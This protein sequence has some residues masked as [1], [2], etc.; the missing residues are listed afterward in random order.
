MIFNNNYNYIIT[1]FIYIILF[2]L[3]IYFLLNLYKFNIFVILLTLIITCYFIINYNKYLINNSVNINETF[4]N[5]ND[6]SLLSKNKPIDIYK[7]YLYDDK[8]K[9][10]Y[11]SMTYDDYLK[12]DDIILTLAD[13]SSNKNKTSIILH[14]DKNEVNNHNKKLQNIY[15]INLGCNSLYIEPVMENNKNSLYN[16]TQNNFSFIWNMK[17]DNKIFN[18]EAVKDTLIDEYNK[19][20]NNGIFKYEI[21][22][23]RNYYNPSHNVHIP[24]NLKCNYCIRKINND[25][26]SIKYLEI[27]L[28]DGSILNENNNASLYK[29]LYE[30]WKNRYS[31]YKIIA[32]DTID[33]NMESTDNSIYGFM[34]DNKEHTF[35]LIRENNTLKLYIDKYLV[36]ISINNINNIG[37]SFNIN[38]KGHV[39][40]LFDNE[41]DNNP[42]SFFNNNTT[43]DINNNNPGIFFN[44]NKMLNDS[45]TYITYIS[46][47]NNMFSND[48]VKILNNN[49]S[50]LSQK[51]ILLSNEYLQN[52]ITK[53]NEVKNKNTL[54]TDEIDKLKIKQKNCNFNNPTLCNICSDASIT[55]WNDI[56]DIMTNAGSQECLN[57]IIHHC[58]NDPLD[59]SCPFNKNI[60][61][62]INKT[63]QYKNVNVQFTQTQPVKDTTKSDT[64]ETFSEVHNNNQQDN[65]DKNNDKNNDRKNNDKNNNNKKKNDKKKNDKNNNKK[66]NENND[67]IIDFE[68][69]E[70]LVNNVI[71]NK[72]SSKNNR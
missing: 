4:A 12:I 39:I 48:D 25:T 68:L 16:F 58:Y 41:K 45:N 3:F 38:N 63:I 34:S 47:F 46:I 23:I 54:L 17:V 57:G 61:D 59:T 43:F 52:T 6:V 26:F 20:I 31:T 21:F 53:Y 35:S 37:T 64:P 72:L 30:T 5:I 11:T 65:N 9:N 2:V 27:E 40:K 19:Y 28:D 51:Y 36:P 67:S 32:Y 50:S 33:E 14:K 70:N 13:L 1:Y 29:E 24:Y 8:Y 22:T 15:S 42:I 69:Y 18:I 56:N 49:I 7:K 55:D 60:L 66:N 44:E 71:K 10:I 62:T